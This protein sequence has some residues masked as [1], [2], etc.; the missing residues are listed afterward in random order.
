LNA[1]YRQTPAL[2]EGDCE[3]WGFAWIDCND[4]ELSAVSFLRQGQSP[5]ALVLVVCNFTPV[6]R[7]NYQVGVP[8]AG[9]WCEALN[10]DANHYGGSGHGNLGE[11]DAAPVPHHGRPYSLMLTLPPLAVVFFI[12]PVAE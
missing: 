6:P 11:V 2:Y 3:P 4:A 12:R 10:S 8:G 5:Q 9:V 7:H 1:L